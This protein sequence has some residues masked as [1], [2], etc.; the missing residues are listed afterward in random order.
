MFDVASILSEKFPYVRVD[1]YYEKDKIYFGELT[2]YPQSGFDS[3]LLPETDLLFG[4]M[5]NL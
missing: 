5:I 2:F 1:L 4:S 3:N